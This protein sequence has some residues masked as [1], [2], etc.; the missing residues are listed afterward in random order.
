MWEM[1]F[2]GLKFQDDYTTIHSTRRPKDLKT[3]QVNNMCTIIFNFYYNFYYNYGASTDVGSMQKFKNV[4]LIDFFIHAL[5]SKDDYMEALNRVLN[6]DKMKEYLSK[7]VVLFPG[8]HPSQFFPRQIVYEILCK[9]IVNINLKTPTPQEDLLSLVPLIGPLHIDLNA[10]ENLVLNYHTFVKY[11]Y[12]LLIP[13]RILAARPKPWRIQFILEII[14]GGWTLIKR[15]VKAVFQKCKNVQYGTLLNFL[16]NY[17]PTLLC[18]FSILFKTNDFSYYYDSILR[19]WVVMYCF[20][21][22][23]YRNL[24]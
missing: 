24:C 16:D 23:H 15:T 17:C 7:F 10:D 5:K 22:Q 9:Y 18:S 13:N 6:L 3:S 19:M 14:Y 8:D 2:A 12:E 11:M 21:R 1:P 4:Y 20:R